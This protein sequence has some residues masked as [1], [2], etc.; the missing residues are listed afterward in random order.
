LS[1]QVDFFGDQPAHGKVVAAPLD[2]DVRLLASKIPSGLR[3]G[4]STWSFSGWQG[5]VYGGEYEETKLSRDGLAAYARHPLLRSVG[6]D[7]SYYRPLDDKTL[8]R[9]A[10]AVGDEFRFL[11]K[12]HAALM[13]PKSARRPEYLLGVPDVFLDAAY[14]SRNVIEPALRL[15][16]DKL[17]VI[18][19][20][21]SP[22]GDRVLRYRN[23]LLERL[24]AFLSAL[25]KEVRYA[26]EWRDAAMLGLDLADLLARHKVSYGFA[27]HPRM[28][29]VDE[30]SSFDTGEGPMV[31]RW[32][33]RRDRAY[34]EAR[35]TYA[36]FDRLVEPDSESR[37]RILSLLR[38][39]EGQGREALV[40]VNNKAEGSAPLSVLQLAR[41]WSAVG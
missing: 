19:F 4:T 3:F 27:A 26:V 5:L 39:A 38:G 7:R 29:N 33:L 30:Q 37:H 22:L 35:A 2:D 12:A 41:E 1:E 21:F 14:A 8:Q 36:P 25:P 28:P 16:G 13:L 23:E 18:L 32:L 17:G 40:I 20:Q 34:D 6:V 9:M 15:L 31:I 10:D 11:M 24:E